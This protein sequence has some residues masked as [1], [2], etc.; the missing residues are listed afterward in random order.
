[1][2][3]EIDHVFVLHLLRMLLNLG[4]AILNVQ[5]A[6]GALGVKDRWRAAFGIV[7][8]AHFLF[9]LSGRPL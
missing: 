4:F 7:L 8:G 9:L 6:L 3:I 1:M 2:I 5:L